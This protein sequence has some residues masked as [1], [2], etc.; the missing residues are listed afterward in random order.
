MEEDA[1]L[2]AKKIKDGPSKSVKVMFD[3]LPDEDHATITH[4]AVFNA[5]R[6]LYPKNEQVKNH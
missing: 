1:R 2:L 6:L 4:Q 5:F 3:Y